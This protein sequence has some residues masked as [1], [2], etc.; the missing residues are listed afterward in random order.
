M[1][2]AYNFATQIVVL[3]PAYAHMC[4]GLHCAR[5]HHHQYFVTWP[6]KCVFA[7]QMPEENINPI[8]LFIKIGSPPQM[9]NKSFNQKTKN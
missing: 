6:K 9:Q 2:V 1:D 5:Q 4:T 8:F 7:Q 3:A